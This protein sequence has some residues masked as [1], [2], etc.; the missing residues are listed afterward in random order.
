MNNNLNYAD[1]INGQYDLDWLQDIA[2][3]ATDSSENAE[4]KD[5]ANVNNPEFDG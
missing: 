1:L 5:N 3:N 4:S 2:N